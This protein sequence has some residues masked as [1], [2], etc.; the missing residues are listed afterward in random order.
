[1]VSNAI[2]TRMEASQ[3]ITISIGKETIF[4]E[5]GKQNHCLVNRLLYFC[6]SAF[7]PHNQSES[8]QG[9]RQLV[10]KRTSTPQTQTSRH[11]D[12]NNGWVHQGS[13]TLT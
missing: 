6:V 12:P 3:E 1:M 4:T 9:P 11:V 10:F 5:L 8:N 13:K 7:M 2:F